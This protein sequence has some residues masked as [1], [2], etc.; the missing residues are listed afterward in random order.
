MGLLEERNKFV[1]GKSFKVLRSGYVFN[2]R[3]FQVSF[4]L[5]LLLA[6]AVLVYGLTQGTF[7]VHCTDDLM[8]G[9]CENPFYN[10]CNFDEWQFTQG[11]TGKTNINKFVIDNG[12]CDRPY[13]IAGET[14]GVAPPFWVSDYTTIIALVLI[15]AFGLNH[16]L[17]NR[18]WKHDLDD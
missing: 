12:L 14:F 6:V 8:T 4:A 17:Y 10:N 3:I 15:I 11:K 7:Y 5:V 2:K 18:G 9:R 1:Y 16:F 13:L